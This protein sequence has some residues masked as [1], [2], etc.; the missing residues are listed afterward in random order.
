M[1]QLEHGIKIVEGVFE[2]RMRESVT[3]DANQFGFVTADTMITVGRLQEEC[4][5]MEKKLYMCF[6][7]LR[8]A[9]DRDPRRVIEWELRRKG[10]LEIPV[11]T[12]MS[13][14]KGARTRV[15]VGSALSEEL[16]VKL[17][18]HQESVL[19]PLLFTLVVDVVTDSARN[20]Q[21]LEICIC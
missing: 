16:E 10:V 12:V 4:R 20:G 21:L 19:S 11:R 7:D 2:K 1:K 6:V 18:G 15:W 8:K 14:H 5:D 9:F 13:L 3:S 17:W